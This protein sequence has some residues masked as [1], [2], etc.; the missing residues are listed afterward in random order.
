MSRSSTKKSFWKNFF[1]LLII[2]FFIGSADPIPGVSGGTIAFIS[3]IY[4][5]LIHSLKIFD[6]A[7][8]KLILAVRFKT[9]FNRIEWNFFLPL[10]L[11][12]VSALILVANLIHYALNH[13]PIFLWSFFLGLIFF[14]TLFFLRKIPFNLFTCFFIIVGF[15]VGYFLL[16]LIPIN[17]STTYWFIFLCGVIAIIALLLPGVSGSFILVI[18]GKYNLIIAS[19]K[20]PLL[21]DNAVVLL[22]FY[23]GMIAGLLCFVHGIYWV[24]KKWEK[25]VLAFLGGLTFGSLR[26]IW[27][28]KEMIVQEKNLEGVS[29]IEKNILPPLDTT[30]L[31]TVFFI[32]LGIA[33]ASLISQLPKIFKDSHNSTHVSF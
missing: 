5:R 17:T 2:G 14:S 20:N 18:L 29:L 26:K 25:F 9:A 16:G 1:N 8:L 23:A 12:I 13:Y 32:I 15:L 7:F 27:P 21:W 33:V 10:L 28:W 4:S 22:F 19:L 30:L 24:M 6:L 31:Y 3:G 11:G